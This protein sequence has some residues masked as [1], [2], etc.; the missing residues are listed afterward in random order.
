MIPFR[1]LPVKTIASKVRATPEWPSGAGNAADAGGTAKIPY[2][3]I[4][5]GYW[6]KGLGS[7]VTCRH[8]LLASR[9]RTKAGLHTPVPGVSSRAVTSPDNTA[10]TFQKGYSKG[11][12]AGHDASKNEATIKTGAV[13]PTPTGCKT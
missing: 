3:R 10:H 13:L 5:G 2:R 7:L 8:P 6:E 4:K 11:T 1:S 12:R 9:R